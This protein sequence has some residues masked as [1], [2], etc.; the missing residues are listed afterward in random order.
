M[1]ILLISLCLMACSP[2]PAPHGAA[3]E[4]GSGIPVQSSRTDLRGEWRLIEMNGQTPAATGHDSAVPIT[5]T[6]GDFTF[7][8]R[9]QCVAFW[10]R[11]TREGDQ[12][13][14]SMAN[15]GAMCARGLS[16]WETE[17]DRTLSTVV[18]AQRR[19]DSLRLAGPR[20]TLT[21][22]P[23]PPEPLT[24]I[25]GRWRL[26]ILHGSTPPA[27]AAPIEITITRGRIEANACVFSGWHYRQDGPL[28][29]V[30]P[31][32]GAV[33]ERPTSPFEQNFG[34][35][36]SSVIR[37]TIIQ[38]GALILDSPSEQVEFRRIE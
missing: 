34:A 19:G 28:L 17:F 7:R 30:T 31:E 9:S 20:S 11:Y 35:F 2:A 5:M 29:E 15:P 32:P 37:A 38:G 13:A 27:S 1:R 6:V 16:R 3:E 10:R 14:V 21:F 25:T 23:A 18:T 22:A 4:A 26:H 24:P 12:L 36:M 8:A 33:C